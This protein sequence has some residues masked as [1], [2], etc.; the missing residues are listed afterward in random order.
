MPR[1]PTRALPG[2][3][4]PDSPTALPG[5]ILRKIR[6][7]GGE[8]QDLNNVTGIRIRNY[9]SN[10]HGKRTPVGIAV[11]L[12]KHGAQTGPTV[13]SVSKRKRPATALRPRSGSERFHKLSPGPQR[14][15]DRPAPCKNITPKIQIPT[16][17][18]TTE[19]PSYAFF[20]SGTALFCPRPKVR[21]EKESGHPFSWMFRLRLP[22]K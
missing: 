12:S 7:E 16:D 19:R 11:P 3:F 20:L 6:E 22:P 5:K 21:F 10:A 17:S 18:P 14:H 2:R 13:Y 4:L 15:S 1:F 9:P 8:N